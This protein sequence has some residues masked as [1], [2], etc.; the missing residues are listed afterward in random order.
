MSNTLAMA[1]RDIRQR[2]IV[3]PQ[4]LAAC[5]IVILGVGAI[6]R[7]VALQL[8]AVGAGSIELFDHDT[9]NVENLAPQAYWPRDIGRLKVDATAEAC[10]L[11]NP[12]VKLVLHPERFRRS[13]ARLIGEAVRQLAI[14]CCV[15][16]ISTRSLAWD[17]LKDRA[18]FFVDGRMNA[19]VT[20]VLA[21][22]QPA[23]D[24]Y[25]ATTLF[26]EAEAYA[27]SCTSRS[28]IY[29]AGIAAGLMLS[30]FTR[31]LRGIAVERDILLNLLS[32]EL[33]LGQ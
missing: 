23:S 21:S 26:A 13:S 3:P 31:W 12:D 19:E 33:S 2:D 5:H 8:A 18:A 11:I 17:A 25:Y 24:S 27:G 14:F 28:T 1:D 16:S 10:R 30:Q 7:Q 6:G 4:K 22:D 29:G 15:D 20:R 9:V 32:M